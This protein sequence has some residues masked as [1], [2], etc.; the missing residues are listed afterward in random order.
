VLWRLKRG[1]YDM[2]WLKAQHLPVP[3]LVVGNV[4]VGGVGKTPITME[5]ARQL[6][7]LGWRP[8]LISRGHGRLSSAVQ[9]VKPHSLASDVGDEPLLMSRTTQLPVAVG[10]QRAMAGRCLL[11]QHPEVN[12]LIADDG[13]QHLAMHHDLALCV[14]DARGL[15]NGWLLP[16][17]PLREPW[18]GR[19]AAQTD[20]CWT[21]SSEPTS[22]PHDWTIER[23]VSTVARNGHGQTAPLNSLPGPLH[24]VAGIA[25]PQGFFE[26]L[27]SLGVNLSRTVAMPDHAPMQDWQPD[28]QGT[29]LCTEKDAVKIWPHHPEVWAVP[30]QVNLPSQLIERIDQRLRSPI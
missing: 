10:T 14:F 26:G 16:A 22:E 7:R 8:G 20:R 24:A 15:G 25:Q 3:V 17:G 2:G 23:Q 1:L 4:M 18:P 13:L 29:W 6:Q 27:R 19:H 11:A 30:L 12:L 21:L 28:G 9:L 5:L